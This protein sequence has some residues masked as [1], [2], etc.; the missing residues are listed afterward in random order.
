MRNSTN[1]SLL[2]PEENDSYSVNDMNANTEFIDAQMK[3][4]E[5]EAANGTKAANDLQAH[6]TNKSN[7]HGVTKEQV[8]LGNVPNVSTNNQ[9]PTYTVPSALSAMSSGEVLSTAFG[10]LAKGVSELISHVG[11]KSNPHGVTKAQIG[12]GNV[13]DVSTN[14]QTP[15]YSDTTTLATLSSGEKLNVAFQKIK[16]AI[17][18]LISHLADSVSHITSAERSS[19]N[20]KLDKTGGTMTGKVVAS[21]GLDVIATET[22]TNAFR[23]GRFDISETNDEYVSMSLNDANFTVKYTN[24]E[25]TNNITFV[26]ENTDAEVNASG[27]GVG[28]QANTSSVVFSGSK[29]GSTVTATSFKGS[30]TG[31]AS[32]ATKLQTPR[33]ISLAGDVTGSVSFDGSANVSMT[34]AIAD[35]SHNHT[36][37]N[38]DGLQAALDSKA[39]GFFSV[40]I[41]DMAQG[42]L[43]FGWSDTAKALLVLIDGYQVGA[44]YFGEEVG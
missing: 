42:R 12:L 38:I 9:A 17:S 40:S 22:A 33:T 32:T 44:L 6:V 23:I 34:T 37:A 41:Y 35:D 21:G 13:P 3:K 11:N 31:N 5:N 39:D 27:S 20:G 36:I 28:A 14:D 7:P 16:L 25:V 29:D 4:V 2:L 1:Y 18:R 43:Q 30:L 8:G 24:D 10:K 15:T 19:W 26:M